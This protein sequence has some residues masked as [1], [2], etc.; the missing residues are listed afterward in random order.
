MSHCGLF[1]D[2]NRIFKFEN[3]DEAYYVWRDR[4]LSERILLHI[5]AHH[6]M[7]G[8]WLDKN[9]SVTIANFILPLCKKIIREVGLGRTRRIREGRTGRNDIR[10]II[11]T[12]RRNGIAEA[13]RTTLLPQSAAP[14]FHLAHLYTDTA[15]RG[16]TCAL[17]LGNDAG[18]C[19]RDHGGL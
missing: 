14:D 19:A 10:R 3:H 2:S 4:R 7:Y 15:A 11:K 9:Q 1:L 8:A 17:S 5:D 13:K 6:D 16:R 18:H 12:L